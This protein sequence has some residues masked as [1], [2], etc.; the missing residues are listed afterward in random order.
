MYATLMPTTSPLPL[1]LRMSLPP[2]SRR[3]TATAGG[4][5][6]PSDEITNFRSKA[7]M[8]A[9]QLGQAGL[10]GWRGKVADRL[11]PA[12]AHRTSLDVDQVRSAV[13][14]LFLIL[15]TLYLVKALRDLL[16]R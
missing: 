12:V 13:G 8:D 2:S 11:A 15:S 14:G 1:A 10:R 6:S 9:R 3:P 7:A 5:A 4:L 16:R